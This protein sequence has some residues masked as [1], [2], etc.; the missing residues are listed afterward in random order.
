MGT[1]NSTARG[2]LWGQEE[3]SP[4]Y[5]YQST[6]YFQK[7][8]NKASLFGKSAFELSFNPSY[9][10]RSL[11]MHIFLPQITTHTYLFHTDKAER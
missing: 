8:L 9:K 2:L 10:A 7:S 4:Y 11:L 1:V 5:S 3:V 6:E